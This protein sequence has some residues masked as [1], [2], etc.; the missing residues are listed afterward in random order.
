MRFIQQIKR[1]W[2][3][4]GSNSSIWVYRPKLARVDPVWDFVA[5]IFIQQISYGAAPTKN[6][7]LTLIY[8]QAAIAWFINF[9]ANVIAS[10]ISGS[11]LKGSRDSSLCSAVKQVC[12]FSQ[13]I[14]RNVIKLHKSYVS[15]K[16]RQLFV[17]IRHKTMQYVIIL[18]NKFS[19]LH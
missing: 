3:I 14:G 15:A 1:R 10:I 12:K 13:P 9:N 7:S 17:D 19:F 2:G 11:K 6:V 18:Q 4:F 16:Y 5:G 8:A